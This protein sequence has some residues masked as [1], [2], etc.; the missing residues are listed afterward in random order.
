MNSNSDL[1]QAILAMDAYNRIGGDVTARNLVVDTTFS[2]TSIYRMLSVTTPRAF[3]PN[4]MLIRP[5]V[6]K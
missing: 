4:R 3:L 1:F 6:K 5:H 2:A